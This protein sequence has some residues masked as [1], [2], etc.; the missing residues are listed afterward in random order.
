[1]SLWS[2][3][4]ELRLIDSAAD[5]LRPY[6]TRQ[7]RL[8]IVLGSGLGAMADAVSRAVSVDYSDIPGFAAATVAGHHGR[9]VI[10]DWDEVPVV[11]M[12]GR[13]HYYEGHDLPAVAR[14][15]RV[16]Q[17]LGVTTVILTNAAGGLDPDMAPG[18]LMLL[19]DHLGFFSESPLRGPNLDL[20]GERFIDQT[21][22]YDRALRRIAIESAARLG[23]PLREGVY[24]Y[25]RGPQYETPAEI[26]ALRCSERTRSACQPY[27]KRLSPGMADSGLWRSPVSAIWRLECSISHSTIR[28]SWRS[29][30]GSRTGPSGFCQR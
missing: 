19:S 14:P 12:Q 28:K 26:R 30:S 24:A 22:V 18:D 21:Q 17:R 15:M 16:L 6:W 8:A 10:G 27:R 2:Q 9:L 29:A 20:F 13:F 1:M 3:E 11:V 4:T 25:S 7:P 23:L 5:Y